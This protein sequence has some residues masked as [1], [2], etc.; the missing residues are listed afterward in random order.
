MT[1]YTTSAERRCNVMTLHRRWSDV[2]LTSCACW[3]GTS[4][5]RHMCTAHVQVRV[6]ALGVWS[7][8]F[9][10]GWVDCLQ[11]SQSIQC[12]YTKIS[13]DPRDYHW[14]IQSNH[15]FVRNPSG[16]CSKLWYSCRC[17][18]SVSCKKGYWKPEPL[19]WQR[20]QTHIR[21]LTARHLTRVCTV[22]LNN[23]KLRIKWNGLKATFRTFTQ[24]TL[25]CCQCFEFR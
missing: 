16:G 15:V 5:F 3:G 14:P 9:R 17:D 4:D 2:V 20:V 13:K 22:R 10:K 11:S 6:R 1:F 24:P 19:H 25:K 7:K 23:R 18:V 21:H 12:T 8:H